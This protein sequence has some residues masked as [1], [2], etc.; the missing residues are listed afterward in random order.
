MWFGGMSSLNIPASENRWGK[1]NHLS[2][3]VSLLKTKI[4][5]FIRV[6][7]GEVP[8]GSLRWF[9][10]LSLVFLD[11]KFR[12]WSFGDFVVIIAQVFL[13]LVVMYYIAEELSELSV[14]RADYLMNGMNYVVLRRRAA[15]KPRP[16]RSSSGGRAKSGVM[17]VHTVGG[18]L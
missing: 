11:S 14:V 18:K 4:A 6:P 7:V 8:K 15:G 5:S 12:H 9:S 17:A 16:K 3:C 1:P 2:Q 13:V 10:R